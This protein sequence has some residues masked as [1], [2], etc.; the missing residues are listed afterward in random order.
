MLYE[1]LRVIKTQWCCYHEKGLS[2]FMFEES[3]V[4]ILL[5]ANQTFSSKT[6][7]KDILCQ[8]MLYD[9]YKWN[10]QI[11]HRDIHRPNSIKSTYTFHLT[12]S[13]LEWLMK[14]W[15]NFSKI[16]NRAFKTMQTLF[17]ALCSSDRKEK[18][19]EK[20]HNNYKDKSST[21]VW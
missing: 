18:F 9:A 8:L 13:K 5:H 1:M 20:P 10:L 4:P 14:L 21:G 15:S 12:L 7:I 3:F 6:C 11:V 16:L 19:E 2:N 17:A